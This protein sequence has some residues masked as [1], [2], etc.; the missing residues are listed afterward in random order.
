M[1]GTRSTLLIVDDEPSCREAFHVAL[2]DEYRLIE[3]DSG[4]IALSIL[5][6]GQNINLMLL[7][8]LLPPWINGLEVLQQMTTSDYSVPVIL[9]T[10]HG[11]QM[12]CR[13]AFKFGVNDYIKKP[14]TVNELQATIKGA[15]GSSAGEKTPVDQAIEFVEEHYSQPISVR[16]VAEAIHVSYDHLAHLFKSEKG[17]SIHRWLSNLRINKAKVLLNDSGLEIKEVAVQTGFNDQN[18]F[19]RLFKK[20]TGTSPQKYRN[21]SKQD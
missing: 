17:S 6:S 18:Y 16:D 7:D 12:I 1:N 5:G 11:S 10:G 8:Y 3:A 15:L 4:N 21:R 13:D 2:E 19:C 9:V 20:Y 14:F